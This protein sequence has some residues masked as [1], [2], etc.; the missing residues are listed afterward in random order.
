MHHR[1]P[2]LA[3]RIIN[4][5]LAIHPQHAGVIMAAI[6]ARFGVSQV[7]L[8]G[9]PLPLLAME[10]DYEFD[11]GRSGSNRD[12]KGFDLI[13]GV[14]FIPIEGTLVHKNGTIRPY[15][16]MTGYDGIRLAFGNALQDSAVRAIVLAIDSPGGEVAGCFD[17]VDDI[18]AARGKKPIWAICDEVAYSAAYLIASSA[19]VISVPRTG[20]AGSIGVIAM[21]GDLSRMYDK[22]GITVNILTFGDYK[23]DGSEFRQLS[24]EARVRFQYWVDDAGG[25][26]VA[27][28]ARNRDLSPDAVKNTKAGTFTAPRA[29]D[30]D[31]IDLVAS[32]SQAFAM[33]Q[34]S[35][36]T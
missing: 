7:L 17:L 27:A 26:F 23:A 36:K 10:D 18:V 2:F 25:L 6:G 19:D 33:L 5:P 20:G 12:D 15:C 35:L 13:D 31:L 32:P 21:L 22:A 16:G 1:L 24:D 4:T 28:V 3:G 30:L 29:L 8:E 9:N 34:A 11:G 14:A